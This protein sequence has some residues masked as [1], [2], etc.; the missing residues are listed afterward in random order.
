MSKMYFK[1]FVLVFLGC[2][3]SSCGFGPKPDK[4]IR[5]NVTFDAQLESE[6][7]INKIIETL[8]K[9]MNKVSFVNELRRVGNK[10]QIYLEVATHYDSKRITNLLIN[11]GKLDFYEVY[12]LE[13]MMNF[14][15]DINSSAKKGDTVQNP[16]FDLFKSH[17]HQGGP[18]LC[19]VSE[20]DTSKVN[21][22]LRL[23]SAESSLPAERRFVKFLWG[24]KEKSTLDLP[25]YAL[26]LNRQSKPYI[27]GDVVKQSHQ[28]FDQMG[29]PVIIMTMNEKGATQWEELTGRAF[30]ERSQIAMV[31]D[32]LVYSAPGVS[33]GPI[34]GGVSQISGDF[35]LEKAQDLATILNSGPIPKMRLL[36]IHIEE[37]Q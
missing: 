29:K 33:S 35:T 7:E 30:Q 5:A 37:S 6:E 12:N 22:L 26:K 14:M 25:L 36:D 3:I 11:P 15:I 2:I 4:L 10:N 1:F 24:I 17:G 16:L 20:K 21:S 32:N 9:R 23:K 13:K 8:R 19:S 34:T 28:E 27:T 31:I 18:I